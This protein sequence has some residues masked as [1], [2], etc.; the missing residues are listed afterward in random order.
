MRITPA[1]RALLVAKHGM[2]AAASDHDARD[3]AGRLIGRGE[4]NLEDDDV[5]QSLTPEAATAVKSLVR[6]AISELSGDNA[7]RGV[8]AGAPSAKDIFGGSPPGNGSMNVTVKTASEMYCAKKS[9]GAHTR[10]GQPVTNERGAQVE[11]PSQREL[12]LFG[13]FYKHFGKRRG[14]DVRW[15]E[16]DRELM[17]DLFQK[18][19]WVGTINNEYHESISGLEV[20]ALLSDSTSGGLEINPIVFDD[21]IVTF[22]LL[23]SEFYPYV[24]L[25]P[26]PRGSNVE[27][28]SVGNPTVSWGPPEGTSIAPFDTDSLVAEIN[29]SIYPIQGAVEMGKDLLSD[30]PVDVG[31]TI[32][33]N[34]GQ[35]LMAEL[36]KV[37]V[38]G[39]GTNQPT[40]IF[41]ASG[42]ASV[43]P[44]GGAGAPIEVDDI[45]GLMFGVA[46]QYRKPGRCSF[47]SNDT[48]YKRVRGIPVDSSSDARRIFGMSHNDYVVFDCPWRVQNDI[49]NPY[50]GFGDLK[51]YRLYR[52]GGHESEYIT[53]SYDLAK[54]NMIALIVRGRYG[55]RV[56]NANAFAKI[57]N[58]QA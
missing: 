4:I 45:E 48:T 51:S 54:R 14:I 41:N 23:H 16:H 1:F 2:D 3:F 26:L 34:I 38:L 17:E 24:D 29:T 57:T 46:K 47:F 31:R 28:A 33:D 42:I 35:S 19:Q 11:L 43:T 58:S 12:A 10:T 6:E 39:S 30:S 52:R 21:L 44:A 49:T 55:G 20:K 32:F 8:K 40:G 15:T 13:A 5:K 53:G 56:M 22:P 36:D 37:I 50:L 9:I 27:G 7:P 25:R 18:H